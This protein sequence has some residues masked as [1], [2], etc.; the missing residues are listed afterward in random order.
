MIVVLFVVGVGVL[1]LR[2]NRWVTHM[3]F[4]SLLVESHWTGRVLR[5]RD[6]ARIA[7]IRVRRRGPVLMAL[8]WGCWADKFAFSG[9]CKASCLDAVGAEAFGGHL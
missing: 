9:Q 4:Q 1:R 7:S 5:E 6:H 3:G 8:S 2:G